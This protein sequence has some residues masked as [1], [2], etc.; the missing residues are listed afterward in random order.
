MKFGAMIAPRISDWEILKHAEDLGYD[1]GWVPDSQ[2]IWSDCYAVLALAAANTNR[3]RLGTG[4]AIAPTRLAPVTAHSIASINQIAPGRTFLGIGTGH[5]AM[6]V[7][8]MKPMSGREFRD[9]LEV[10]HGLLNGQEVEYT[11]R[12]RKRAIR[13]LHEGMGFIDVEQ[14]VEIYVAANGPIALRAAGEFGDGRI[15]GGNERTDRLQQSLGIIREGAERSGRTLP[16]DF[17]TAALTY[18]CVLKPG[19]NIDSDRVIDEVGSMVGSMLHG[20]WERYTNT[21]DDAF[22]PDSCRDEWVDYLAYLEQHPIPAEKR[23]QAVHDGHCTYLVP[24]ERRFITPS[25][26]RTGNA[27]IGEPDAI[28][29]QLRRLEAAGLKEVTLLPPMARARENFSEFAENVM[30]RY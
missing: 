7:M 23:Y 1:H 16:D 6:R 24:E 4:V 5:T 18:A 11:Y 17:H 3:I 2:M 9:Y 13:F 12:D 29:D 19:E 27:L 26:I 15:S 25:V 8:G 20:W 14:R 30:S 10:V 22:V 28:I 21:G